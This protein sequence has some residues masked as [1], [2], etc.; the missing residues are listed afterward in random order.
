MLR[1]TFIERV[2]RSIYNGQPSDDA[3]ITIGLVNNYL[4]DAIAYA[5]KA[6]YKEN[7]AVD[8][9]GYVNNSFIT[10]FKNVAITFDSTNIWKAQLPEIPV[11]IGTNGGVS[12][13]ELKDTSTA[14]ISRSLVP[15][16][17]SQ[18]SFYKAMRPI[19]NK[20][21]YYY[22]GR[23]IYMVTPITLH[24]YT[25][26]ITMVSGGDS[27][28]L[29]SELNVPPDYFPIMMDYLQKQ[30]LLEKAQPLDATNDGQDFITT[31]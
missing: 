1:I 6:N 22:E 19:P 11:G 18:R 31:T 8:G 5:A 3:T 27:T 29:Y 30:L 12:T 9:I 24:Q 20:V 28:D 26:N 23:Y 14:E 16:S 13:L 25:A 21:L 7:I 10:T 17:E 2:R 4:G 15:M